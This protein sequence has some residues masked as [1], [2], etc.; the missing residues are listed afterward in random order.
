MR[1]AILSDIHGNI[2]A[3]EAVLTDLKARGGADVIAIAGDLCL[4]GPRPREVLDL[5][6]SL[7]SPV[8]QGNTDYSL[9]LT[10]EETADSE[11]ADLHQ[12]TR[13]Q[14][15]A[16]GIEY[17]RNLPFAH[18]IREPEG[19]G[20]VLIVHANPQDRDQH[21]RPLAPEAQIAP[22][23]EGVA[24]EVTTIAF[25]HLHI[26]YVRQVG[27]L[28]LVDVASVGLPKD[29]DRR[30]GYGLFTWDDGGWQIEQRRVE[31]PVE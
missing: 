10:P 16:D 13:E 3:L 11:T 7:G 14:I 5:V 6:R 15:G 27:R 22:L 30:A 26:P 29:G 2:L 9:A 21:L 4:D 8:V 18:R 31:Y 23:L 28:R 17:L 1:L 12:W 25:G 19:E 24:P 20:V